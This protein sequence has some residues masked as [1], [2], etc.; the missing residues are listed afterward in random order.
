[1]RHWGSSTQTL[2][3]KLTTKAIKQETKQD[4]IVYYCQAE[5]YEMK[6][7]PW[8]NQISIAFYISVNSVY[9]A[10]CIMMHKKLWMS[11]F[12]LGGCLWTPLPRVGQNTQNM[13]CHL[14]IMQLMQEAL[15]FHNSHDHDDAGGNNFNSGKLKWLQGSPSSQHHT[16]QGTKPISKSIYHP[17]FKVWF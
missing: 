17:N 5:T 14:L 13:W 16:P 1:M 12:K 7:Q 9:A 15:P 11:V 4:Y 10:S 2:I 6:L 8:I 3:E